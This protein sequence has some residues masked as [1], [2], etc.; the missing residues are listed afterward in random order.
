MNRIG[1][2]II[3]FFLTLNSCSDR[4][5]AVDKDKLLG[6]DYR[7]F[8]KTS[9]WNLAKAVQDENIEEIERIVKEG[10]VNLDYQES[11]F[12]QTLLMLTISNQ[13]YKSCKLLLEL[14][15]NPNIHNTYNGSSAI[16]D[17]ANI[18]N[19]TGDNTDFLRLLLE[20]GAN[21][22]DE[23]I[24]ERQEGNTT[25][26]TP[27]LVA[28]GDINQFVSP[29]AKV[30]LLVEAG[31]NINYKNE[32]IN[33]TPLKKALVHNHF[34]VVLYLLQKGVD[35][36]IVLSSVDGKNYYLW[37]ELRFKMPLLNSE[38]HKLKMQ[39]VAFLKEKGIDYRALPIPDY[40]MEE[41]K[42][43]YPKTWKEYLEK[44]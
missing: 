2:I 27:L 37:D 19:F 38:E 6:N 21:A 23:E 9:V 10:E 28:C 33:S 32:Y 43:L 30:K 11:K 13:Q 22:N 4:D 44:Y 41:A 36:Q 39:I 5:T 8:Q 20:Y 3:F 1:L 12:G 25:R 17:A 14:G 26:N 40:V 7:L 35:Y 42:E 16:I 24:G 31:A 18:E 15:A 29:L 34:D